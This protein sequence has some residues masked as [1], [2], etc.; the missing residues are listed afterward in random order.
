MGPVGVAVGAAGSVYDAYKDYQRRK[1]YIEKV[2]ELRKQGV[3]QEEQFDENLPMFKS[4]GLAKLTRT[5]A[6]DSGPMHG[7]L[8]SLYNRAR[9][10]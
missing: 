10:K 5:V 7:G 8:R 2:K 3:I 4:G 1:P 6:P 9:R